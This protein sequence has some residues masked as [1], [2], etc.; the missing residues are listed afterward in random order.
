MPVMM[1][2]TVT[3]EE[4]LTQMTTAIAKLTKTVK[5]KD[6]LIAN[7]MN[8]LEQQNPTRSSQGPSQPLGFTPQGNL[9]NQ[10]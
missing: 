1:T 4:Q 3:V 2:G 10:E 5:E 6:L 9:G 8:K 7:L